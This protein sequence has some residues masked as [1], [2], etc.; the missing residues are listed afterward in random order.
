MPALLAAPLVGIALVVNVQPLIEQK[1]RELGVVLV[2]PN[3]N[4]PGV[5]ATREAITFWNKT[6]LE[7]GLT[8]KF[9]ELRLEV[10]PPLYRA[11]DQYFREMDAATSEKDEPK[12]APQLAALHKS[13]AD[14][15]V[16]L[17]NDPGHISFT[18][19]ELGTFPGTI[20]LRSSQLLPL[21]LPNVARNVAAHELGHVLGLAHNADETMLM[22]G[23]PSE[24]RPAMFQSP[25]LRFFPLTEDDRITL[26]RL[27][28]AK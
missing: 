19:G 22:C 26:K 8:L 9:K 11:L 12:L 5:T 3:A 25:E 21:S 7:L 6:L 23:R 1:P 2:A 17:S 24:C 27:H 14:V 13:G 20:A 18:Y 15:V 10:A 28:S 4:D 16:Y